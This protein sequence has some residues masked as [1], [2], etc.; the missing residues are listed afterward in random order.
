MFRFFELLILLILIGCTRVEEPS[1][2]RNS[3]KMPDQEIWNGKIEISE[4]GKLQSVVRAGYM[5][6]FEKR[7]QTFLDSGVVVDFYNKQGL[8]TSVLTADSAE[9]DERMNL[10]VAQGNVVVTSDS[11]AVLRTPRLYWDKDKQRI[12]SD[13]LAF[14][15]TA[16]DSLRGINF[17]SDENLT[18]WSLAQPT[19]Q[20]LRGRE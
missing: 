2:D 13:T 8:H 19:G 7:K 1:G 15:T 14:L 18:S 6:I 20:T 16:L 5:R 17:E 10:F 4:N 12:R 9:I 3:V 11:G